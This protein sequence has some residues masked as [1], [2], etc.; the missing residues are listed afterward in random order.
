[1]NCDLCHKPINT[2]KEKYTCVQ[3]WEKGVMGKVMW[4][5]ITCFAA[6]MNREQTETEEE[7]KKMLERCGKIMDKFYGK[8]EEVYNLK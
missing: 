8:Q 3:D 1:M 5:H 2:K 4:L 6:A 7:A